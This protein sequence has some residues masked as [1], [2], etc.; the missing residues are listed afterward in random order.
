MAIADTI[1]NKAGEFMHAVSPLEL[2][3]ANQIKKLL[4]PS[5]KNSEFIGAAFASLKENFGKAVDNMAKP[6]HAGIGNYFE[7]Y[8][9][10]EN[11]SSISDSTVALRRRYR[12]MAA[13]GAV[14]YGASQLI[15]GLPA[16]A[17]NFAVQAGA[18]ATV[19]AGLYK[20]NPMAGIAYAGWGAYNVTSPGDN[21]GPF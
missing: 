3:H 12:Q 13:V 10:G 17:T 20:I 1:L 9:I 21:T 2:F 4:G 8:N 14:T 7:G 19:A 6:G 18:N 15:G 5:V 11:M 16:R